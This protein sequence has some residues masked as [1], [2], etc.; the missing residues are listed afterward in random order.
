MGLS[1]L[2]TT[3]LE[4]VAAA[5]PEGLKWFQLYV[6]KDRQVA[7]N[8]IRRAERAGYR[9]L[10]VTVDAPVLGRREADIRHKFQLPPHL[11]LGNFTDAKGSRNNA[12]TTDYGSDGSGVASY[13]TMLIDDTLTWADI[14]WLKQQTHLPIIVKGILTAK[15]VQLAIKTGVDAVWISNHGARQLDTVPAPIEAL[16][17]IHR[18]LGPKLPIPLF[19]DGGIMRGTDVVKALAL[20]ASAVFIGRPMLWGLACGGQEGVERVLEVIIVLMIYIFR[21]HDNF[22]LVF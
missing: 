20:G 17:D 11:H 2:S 13:F 4:D 9:G 21:T 8:L 7:I 1:S 14:A 19:L 3:S 16:Y 18:S 5:A 6:Y 22:S 10:A 15:D 12:S